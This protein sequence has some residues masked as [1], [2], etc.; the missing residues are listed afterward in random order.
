MNVAGMTVMKEFNDIILSYGQSDEYSFVFH[1]SSQLYNRRATKIA[2]YVNSLFTSAYVFN[3]NN[4]FPEKKLNYPPCFDSRTV[5]YPTEQNLKDY[6]SW[7]QAD[8]HINN[9]YNTAFWNL[10]LKGGLTNSEAEA[11][12]R[13]TLSADKNEILFNKFGINYNKISP[14]FRK[15]TILLRKKVD[16][17]NSKSVRQL[18]VPIFDDLIQ[19]KFWKTHHEL[20]EKK[21]PQRYE[22]NEVKEGDGEVVELPELVLMQLENIRVN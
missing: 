11:E 16:V 8:V 6:L 3:W 13:G 14:M 19:E 9:L 20:L 1:K 21:T 12:L 15:G 17:P 4:L 22:V 5:L 7:R 18:I 10:V 2:S